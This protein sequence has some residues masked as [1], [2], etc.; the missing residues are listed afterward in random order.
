MTI[1]HDSHFPFDSGDSEGENACVWERVWTETRER[2]K[3]DPA[4]QAADMEERVFSSIRI[5]E[6][7]DRVN[8][9]GSTA[10]SRKYI[11]RS[12][13]LAATAVAALISVL[14]VVVGIRSSYDIDDPSKT[15]L[16]SEVGTAA[17]RSFQLPDG[18][19][20][21]LSP[22]TSVEYE[23]SRKE[24]RIVT[25]YGQALFKVVHHTDRPFQVNVGNSVVKV[26]G[27]RFNVR[28]FT[29][30]SQTIVSVLDGKVAIDDDILSKGDV[31]ALYVD[32]RI[33][34]RANQD[35]ESMIS[36]AD[37]RM[38]FV[39]VPLESVMQEIARWYGFEF[40]LG[41]ERISSTRLTLRID[42]EPLETVLLSIEKMTGASV[43]RNGNRITITSNQFDD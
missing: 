9:T 33:D 8:I 32:G 3:P 35:V 11:N 22:G 30:D 26:L 19:Q 41:N 18:S 20:V 12:G 43:I 15:H 10:G 38:E 40:S 24:G 34:R 5:R 7:T 14:T 39:A 42:K 16:F 28:K 23:E 17:P 4:V 27:T 6:G 1:E 31:R 25:V 36:W 2:A 21:I 13:I 29:S 37:G